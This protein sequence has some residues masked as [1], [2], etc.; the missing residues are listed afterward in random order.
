MCVNGKVPQTKKFT[1][2][3]N[4]NIRNARENEKKNNKAYYGKNE[5][6]THV[7][8]FVGGTFPFPYDTENLN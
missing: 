7:S 3:T 8:I 5:D 2:V 4:Y 1:C 6:V